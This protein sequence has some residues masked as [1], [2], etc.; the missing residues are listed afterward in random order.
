MLDL[1]VLDLFVHDRYENRNA[2]KNLDK[3]YSELETRLK[4]EQERL[5]GEIDK[6]KQQNEQ[7]QHQLK[8]LKNQNASHLQ[9][10]NEKE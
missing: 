8:E 5:M 9:S 4:S 3:K 10:N 6:V 2:I 1:C 7:L